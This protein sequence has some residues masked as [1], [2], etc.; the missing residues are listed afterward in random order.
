[1]FLTAS[2]VRCQLVT[3]ITADDCYRTK[4]QSFMYVKFKQMKKETRPDTEL[5]SQLED[6]AWVE[7]H[8]NTCKNSL[9][10]YTQTSDNSEWKMQS[11]MLTKCWLID[12]ELRQSSQAVSWLVQSTEPSQPIT[13]LI[14]TKHWA[15]STNHMA[16]IDK[17]E[18][19]H[20]QE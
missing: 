12:T 18:H 13:G 9:V 2:S 19:D 16:D 20:N 6:T 7:L 8:V 4:L 14:L 10:L 3:A 17:T 1:M 11:I 15:F 5:L